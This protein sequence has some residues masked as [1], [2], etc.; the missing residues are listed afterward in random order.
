M[1]AVKYFPDAL[2]FSSHVQ[3]LIYRKGETNL[4][5]IN[6]PLDIFIFKEK[7]LLMYAIWRKVYILYKTR[8]GKVGT[9]AILKRS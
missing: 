2:C 3:E 1:S 5:V 7:N 4:Y 6:N 8:A 9:A